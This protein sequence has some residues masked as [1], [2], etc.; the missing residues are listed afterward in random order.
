ML[1]QLARVLWGGGLLLAPRRLLEQGAP[2]R[3]VSYAT[4][5]LGA[6]H[7]VEALILSRDRGQ[8]PP[9][10]P[11]VVDLIHGAS[12][13]ALAIW[14]PRLRRDALV[15]AAAAGVLGGWAALERRHA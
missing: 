6:R 13:V 11:A 4:R 7:L 1:L 2:S 12:M 3:G 5:A 8:R 15:S 10:W 14:R 9:R